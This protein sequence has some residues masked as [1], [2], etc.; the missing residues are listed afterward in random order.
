MTP[1]DR[2]LASIVAFLALIFLVE[3]ARLIV[4]INACQITLHEASRRPILFWR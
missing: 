4:E 1:N 3:T 2:I